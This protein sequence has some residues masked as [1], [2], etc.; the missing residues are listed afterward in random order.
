[1]GSGSE[2]ST[3]VIHPCKQN[4]GK[5]NNL[6]KTIADSAFGKGGGALM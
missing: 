5:V 1:M 2:D 6:G 3:P 4:R